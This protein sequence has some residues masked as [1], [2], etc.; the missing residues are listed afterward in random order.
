MFYF[1]PVQPEDHSSLVGKKKGKKGKANPGEGGDPDTPSSG[2]STGK[3][4][5]PKKT[6]KASAGDK[7]NNAKKVTT[8]GYASD[9][10]HSPLTN[11]HLTHG[12]QPPLSPRPRTQSYPVFKGEVRVPEYMKVVK[13]PKPFR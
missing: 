1:P 9:E 7:T 6:R 11:G 12:G 5:K 4:K 13:H 10:S 2:S 8:D 3:G